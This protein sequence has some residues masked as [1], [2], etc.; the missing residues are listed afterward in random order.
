MYIL[1]Y[2]YIDIFYINA[3][4][5]AVWV[6]KIIPH[7]NELDVQ[8]IMLMRAEMKDRLRRVIVMMSG[9]D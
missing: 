7:G 5:T 6:K 4:L 1:M 3:N 2:Y 9:V 8:N